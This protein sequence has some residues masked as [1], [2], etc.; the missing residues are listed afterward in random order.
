M[1]KFKNIF[2]MIKDQCIS[3]TDLRTNTKQCLQE[4]RKG[5]KYVFVNNKPVAVILNI[6]EYESNFKPALFELS[7]DEITTSLKKAALKAQKT[8]KKDLLDL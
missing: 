5:P 4:T 2:G 7:N 1:H 6:D 8:P 3:V